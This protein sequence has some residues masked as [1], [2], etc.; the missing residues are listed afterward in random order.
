MV[1]TT[2]PKTATG[3]EITLPSGKTARIMDFK[4]KHIRQASEMAGDDATKVVFAMIAI[5]TTIDGEPVVMED[6]DEMPGKD[7]LVL[8]KEF[9]DANF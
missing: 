7:V 3:K 1:V 2:T 5:C 6:I 4:G 8:Q 9:A